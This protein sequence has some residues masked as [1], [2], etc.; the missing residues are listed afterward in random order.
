[1]PLFDDYFND[2][3]KK[4][5]YTRPEKENDR[6]CHMDTLSAHVG[7]VFTCYPDVARMNAIQ[8]EACK[9]QPIYDFTADDGVQHTVWIVKDKR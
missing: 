5:E 9:A 6:I 8:V 3:I 7:P 1:V 4:H 2:V